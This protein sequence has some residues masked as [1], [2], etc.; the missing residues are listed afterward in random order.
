MDSKQHDRNT[1]ALSPYRVLD[2]TDEKGFLCGRMLAVM[3]AEVIKVEPPCGDRARAFPP[4]YKDDP[5]PEKSLYYLAYNANKKSITL[6][7]ESRDGQDILKRLVKTADFLVESFKPGYMDELGLG[8]AD[9]SRINPGIIM[10]SISPFG[11]T[12][13][14]HDYNS[15]ELMCA[16]MS[17]HMFITGDPDRPP[18]HISIPQAYSLGSA[19]ALIATMA[20]HYYRRQTGEGQH[21]DV[22]I[23]E[24][25]I[26]TTVNTI[27]MWE[28]KGMITERGGQFWMLR[29]EK[30]RVLW[31]CKDGAV[32]F[33]MHGGGFGAKT[34]REL[35]KWMD[36]EGM[37]SDYLKNMDWENLDMETAPQDLYDELSDSIIRFFRTHTKMELSREAL[38]RGIMLAPVQTIADISGSQQLEARVF[39]E[40]VEYPRLKDTIK[41]PGA[42][43]KSSESSCR[44]TAPAPYKGQHN[45]DIYIRELGITGEDLVILKGAGVI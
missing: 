35:V 27:P 32:S 33:G 19:E 15:S 3:G 7:I 26:K 24:A 5:H 1:G 34:N 30:Q 29:G 23:R 39:W 45:E 38:A 21:V 42:F 8:Y 36:S 9:L 12:G 13:P 4:F 44:R 22:S 16:A 37:A 17:G 40:D 28:N 43:I 41:Y 2:L 18:V 11:Q 25:M 31:P 14:Y 10:T 6:D 20:A